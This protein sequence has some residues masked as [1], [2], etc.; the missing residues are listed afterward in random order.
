MKIEAIVTIERP[1]AAVWEFVTDWSNYSKLNPAILQARQ[2]TEGP[3]AVGTIV[4]AKLR[5]PNL[6]QKDTDIR[7]VAYEPNRRIT[8]EHISGSLKGTVTTFDMETVE[9][10][11]RLTLTTDARLNGILKLI[12]PFATSRAKREVSQEAD[13]IKGWLESTSP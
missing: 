7:I 10:R 4:E 9:G 5:N 3:P 8:L 11:T 13:N 12:G 6:V 2:T 1:V